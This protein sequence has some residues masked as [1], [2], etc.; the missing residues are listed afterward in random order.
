MHDRKTRLGHRTAQ[1]FV[2]LLT[3][4][5][6]GVL[7][8]TAGL[9][10][11][12]FAQAPA[13]P[14]AQGTMN[15]AAVVVVFGNGNVN[16]QCV[17][18]P[19][20]EI[21]GLDLLDRAGFGLSV[22]ASNAMGV[23]VCKIGRN[24]CNFPGETCFCQCQGA[25]CVY[26]SYWHRNGGA[27]D[28][29]NMGTSNS[30]V[31]NGDLDGWVWGAGTTSSATAPPDIEFEEVCSIAAPATATATNEPA[32]AT[33]TNEP[34][35][36]TATA[37]QV[38]ATATSTNLPT[39]TRTFI[40][41][42]TYDFPTETIEPFI[43]PTR[44]PAPRIV[45]PTNIPPTAAP[46]PPTVEVIQSPPTIV[47]S[48]TLSDRAVATLTRVAFAANARATR[49]ASTSE[50]DSADSADTGFNLHLFSGVV[51]AVGF[52]IGGVG[53]IMLLGGLGWYLFR[54]R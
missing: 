7:L 22:D 12:A 30:P 50:S 54:R 15:H 39:A 18:F 31:H 25:D 40:P 49:A 51:L 6:V 5:S 20:E 47:P 46:P 37:T 23:A 19:E 13:S 10:Q 2:A 14:A 24:G 48:P 27:W 4:L 8:G 26:W 43:P 16:Q 32:T 29:S 1:A 38:T 34:P 53:T 36:A 42:T 11:R 41:T 3:L 33:A 9:L 28:Y 45:Q 21:T 44:P 52:L 17:A 35:T